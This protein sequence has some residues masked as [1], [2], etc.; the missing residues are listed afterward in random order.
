M[1]EKNVPD[2]FFV[3]DAVMRKIRSLTKAAKAPVENFPVGNGNDLCHQ[4]LC[5]QSQ[6]LNQE[7]K[8][9]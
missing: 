6:R 5:E 4:K 3:S 7:P 8:R 1:T 9:D 2:W